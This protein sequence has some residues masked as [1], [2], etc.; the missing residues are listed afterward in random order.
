MYLLECVTHAQVLNSGWK[1][2]RNNGENLTALQRRSNNRDNQIEEPPGKERVSSPYAEAGSEES[3]IDPF[4]QRRREQSNTVREKYEKA[5]WVMKPILYGMTEADANSFEVLFDNIDT[6]GIRK[7][8]VTCTKQQENFTK[9]HVATLFRII[10]RAQCKP[11]PNKKRRNKKWR[12]RTRRNDAPQVINNPDGS[13]TTIRNCVQKGDETK[14]G[15][16][17]LCSQCHAV[18]ELP[19]NRYVHGY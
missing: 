10:K 5:R 18:T 9:R 3:R 13:V 12:V 8:D 1:R 4:I 2:Y 17:R 14:L 19:P 11:Q 7:T 6:G 15:L 16:L